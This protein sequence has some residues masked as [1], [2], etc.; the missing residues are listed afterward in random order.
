MLRAANDGD[1]GLAGGAN[2]NPGARRGKAAAVTSASSE[3]RGSS[4]ALASAAARCRLRARRLHLRARRVRRAELGFGGRRRRRRR[5]AAPTSPRL[6]RR[7]LI[8]P[9]LISSPQREAMKQV[10]STGARAAA[11]VKA[12]RRRRRP[13]RRRRS[14][15]RASACDPRRLPPLANRRVGAADAAR[16]AALALST[17]EKR[18]FNTLVAKTRRRASRVEGLLRRGAAAMAQRGLRTALNGWIDAVATRAHALAMMGK[19]AAAIRLR[20]RRMAMNGWVG[21]VADRR[22]AL[23]IMGRASSALRHRGRRVALNSWIYLVDERTRARIQCNRAAD[24]LRGTGLRRG[25]LRWRENGAGRKTVAGVLGRSTSAC[26][27]RAPTAGAA[28]S[29]SARYVAGGGGGHDARAADAMNAWVSK[30]AAWADALVM[31]DAAAAALTHRGTRRALNAWIETAKDL[32]RRRGLLRG[33]LKALSP[34]GR[35][36][37]RGLNSWRKMVEERAM[38]RKV[39]TARARPPLLP[40]P[41]PLPMLSSHSTS[42][43]PRPPQHPAP[44]PD[45][46]RV[47]QAAV[48]IANRGLRFGLNAWVERPPSGAPARCCAA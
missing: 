48:A 34:E 3:R 2:P 8:C 32:A 15:P 43:S 5:R 45:R 30:V 39:T 13:S 41:H 7:P 40:R 19:A 22:Y 1:P 38:M 16:R 12:A 31:M 35:A 46:P 23:T 25:L 6:P 11:Q 44:L 18:A 47:L 42:G 29:P 9:P 4:A 26:D 33:A 24:E 20:G 37:R 21:M 17:R 36:M 28:W 14:S 27:A 10:R